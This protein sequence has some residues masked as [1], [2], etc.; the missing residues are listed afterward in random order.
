MCQDP[1]ALCQIGICP[2]RPVLHLQAQSDF[3]SVAAALPFSVQMAKCR[4]SLPNK[5]QMYKAE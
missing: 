1:P 2:A 3:Q 4:I 5:G